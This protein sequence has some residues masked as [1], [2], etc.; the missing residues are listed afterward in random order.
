[1]TCGAD[2]G[3]PFRR[4]PSSELPRGYT[5][6]KPEVR[7]KYWIGQLD[8]LHG[9]VFPGNGMR[10]HPQLKHLMDLHVA[11]VPGL[12]EAAESDRRL[13]RGLPQFLGGDLLEVRVIAFWV[14]MEALGITQ[15]EPVPGPEPAGDALAKDAARLRA[16][17]RKYG[18]LTFPERMRAVLINPRATERA[19]REAADKLA[20]VRP[21]GSL[22]EWIWPCFPAPTGHPIPVSVA[23]LTGPTAA[24]AVLTAYD[25]ALAL[26]EAQTVEGRKD[27]D[28]NYLPPLVQL[29]NKGLAPELTRRADKSGNAVDRS[30]WAILAFLA[31]NAG[32]LAHFAD[33]FAAGN[34]HLAEAEASLVLY[35]LLV[36]EGKR[37]LDT[38]FSPRVR[39]VTH[40]FRLSFGGC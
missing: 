20:R 7:A 36:I 18:S 9:Q 34:M 10:L 22:G 37:R 6:W 25:L 23:G 31:G 24:Q 32:P 1:M 15:I 30:I 8:E 4:A 38:P 27:V 13:T 40:S 28:D 3:W 35:R 33:D 21:D 5:L 39:G 2:K 17:W 26:P 19:R 29:L 11:A 14:A 16:Y 12:I